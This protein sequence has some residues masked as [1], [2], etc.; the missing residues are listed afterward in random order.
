MNI[1]RE[2][3]LDLMKKILTNWIYGSK[4]VKIVNSKHFLQRTIIALFDRFGYRLIMP[5][6]MNPHK[7]LYGLDCPPT[8]HT[9]VGLKRLDNIQKCIEDILA[10]NVPGDIME[11]GVWRGGAAIF[12][13]AV[14]KAHD[15]TDRIV[16]VAD[17]FQGCP[18]PNVE[19]YPQDKS[20]NLCDYKILAVPLEEVKV[21][22]RS[23][24]LL[25][26]Q[27]RFLEGWFKNTLPQA[28]M[29]K[30]AVLRLDGDLYEST[31]DTLTSL[32]PKLSIGGYVIV[33]DFLAIPSCRKAVMI[34]RESNGINDQIIAIDH[35]SVYWKKLR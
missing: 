35:Y 9:M 29:Q 11:C 18:R 15:V 6:P 14:L 12:M 26:E 5:Y 23:Y 17:S 7:R 3:Y 8:A 24:D 20:L 30:L 19:K 4:E 31:M 16:Y 33:D 27:V 1:A 32:Y 28:A 25:D 10:N 2:L 34:Y 13:R 22:F 21:N